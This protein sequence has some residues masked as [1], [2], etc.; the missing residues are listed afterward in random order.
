MRAPAVSVLLVFAGC[1]TLPQD[2]VESALY[3]DLRKVVELSEDG[4]WVIDRAQIRATEESVLRSVCQVDPARRD[5]LDAWI[6]GQ[7]ALAGGPAQRIYEGNGGHLSDASLSLA[8]ER[9]RLLLRH[10]QSRAGQ[11]CPFWLK[12]NPHFNGTQGDAGRFLLLAE[13]LGFASYL[14]KGNVPAFGGGGRVLV[15][16]GLGPRLTFAMGGELAAAGALVAKDKGS[17]LDTTITV[18]LPVLL[19]VTRFS[20]IFDVELAPVARFAPGE[21]SFPPG[22]RVELAGGITTMRGSAF[23][24]YGMLYLAYEYHP[25]TSSA[26][27]DHTLQIGTRLAVE[28]S[29]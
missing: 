9:T 19:R 15:G 3:S 27:A 29:P 12:P 24:P 22:G 17:G 5:D 4:G 8:L 25:P 6:T 26:G 23:M 1:A 20:R 21:D 18:A 11:D 2:P 13:T 28:L 14:F 16:H 7:I 10:G